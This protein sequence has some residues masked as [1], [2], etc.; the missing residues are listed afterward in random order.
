MVIEKAL[1]I[2]R[3][4]KENA[5]ADLKINAINAVKA[6]SGALPEGFARRTTDSLGGNEA[7]ISP[8]RVHVRKSHT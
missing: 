6:F 3:C 8:K 1:P 2:N 5:D 7:L 4:R